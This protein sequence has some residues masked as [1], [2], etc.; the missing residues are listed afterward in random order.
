MPIGSIK[1]RTTINGE[2]VSL[3]S[4]SAISKLIEKK[5]SF[6]MSKQTERSM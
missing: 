6:D 3:V 5:A 1:N 4:S 2:I